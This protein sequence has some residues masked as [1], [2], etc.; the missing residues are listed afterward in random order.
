MV[1]QPVS[2][3]V[4][5][6]AENLSKWT[7]TDAVYTAFLLKM[8]QLSSFRQTDRQT[9]TQTDRQTDRHTDRKQTKAFF[10]LKLHR[11]D[12]YQHFDPETLS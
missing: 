10:V 1:R 7:F 5:I 6:L 11:Y 12:T 2:H 3:A 4:E 8:D 9:D